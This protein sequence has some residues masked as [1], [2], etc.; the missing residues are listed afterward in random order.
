M[1]AVE[2]VTREVQNR[3]T[4]YPA[5]D[6]WTQVTGYID[7]E[8]RF[9]ELTDEEVDDPEKLA[10]WSEH[11]SG[12]TTGWPELLKHGRVVLLA[13]AGAGKTAEMRQ[14]AKRLVGEEK[15]AF[16]VALEE[17][18]RGPIDD[19]LSTDESNR[20]EEW[21]AAADALAWF[22]LDAVDE[23][24]LTQGKLDRA[25]RR[26]SRTLDSRLE[27]ARIII[28]CRP[29][30]WRP[31]LDAETVRNRLP[32]P[33]KSPRVS[34][35]PSEEMFVEAL[36]RAHR[37]T[38]PAA[39]ERR[40]DPHQSVL[41]TFMMLPM[42][43]KQ[44]ERFARQQGL[45]DVAAFLDAVRRHDAWTFARRPLD[46]VAL[47]ET[48]KQSGSLGTRAQRHDTNVTTKLK[49]DP[50]R[51][52][53]DVLSEARAGDGA[54]RLALAL[55]LTRTR[56]IRSPEQVLD[57]A[58]ADGVLDPDEI[59]PDWPTTER[60]SLLRRALFD[61]AT[62]GRV[63]FHHRSTQEYLAARRLR[64]LRKRGMSTKA[65]LRLLLATRYGVDVVYPSMRAIAAWLAL[66]DDA[67][68]NMLMER[69]PEALLSMGDPESLDVNTRARIVRRFVEAYGSGGARGL[70]I[71][72]A[73]VRRLA[74]PEL[75]PVIRECWNA[76]ANIDVRELLMEMIW[77]GAV[78][79][80][81]DL[82]HDV[83]FDRA[84]T[85]Y[86]RV[87]AIRALVACN[88]VDD[89]ADLASSMLARPA[90]WPDRV[91]YGVA[92]DLFPRFITAEQLLALIER[93]E[94][95]KQAAG[96][97]EWISQQIAEAVEPLSAA[98]V[99]LR[100]GLATLVQRGR[101]PRTELYNLCSR[102]DYLA[103]ALATL[104]AR[105]LA[106]LP[107]RPDAA[108]IRASVIA[109]RFVEG[110]GRD[111]RAGRRDLVGTLRTRMAAEPALRKD[112]FWSE[113]A[114]VDE[115]EKTDDGWRRLYYVKDG[116]VDSLSEDDRQWLLEDLADENR[117]D[118]HAVVLHALIGLWWQTGRRASELNEL[119]AH[120]K[121]DREL[122]RI[123]D[124]QTEPPKRDKSIEEQERKHEE[125]KRADAVRENRR[126]EGWKRWRN[127]LLADP[128]KAFSEGKRN[129]T[130]QNIYSF[131]NAL[132]GSQNR[133]D[134]WDKN[135][136]ADTFGSDVADRAED[137]F[138]GLW[139]STRACAWSARS[140]GTRN[141]VPGKWI[142]GLAGVSAEAAT[143]GWSTRLSSKDAGTA[144]AYAMIELNGLA[145]FITD[146]VESHPGEVARVIGTEARAELALS[147]DHEH[148][149]VVDDLAHANAELQRLCVPYLVD[150]LK[151]WPSVADSETD[152]RRPRHLD[153]LLHIL[154]AAD[155]QSV[156]EALAAECAIRY[157]DDPMAGLAVVWLK[158][159]F[160]FDPA[161]GA[162]ELIEDVEGRGSDAAIGK[163]VIEVFAALFDD[164][165]VDL[166]LPDPVQHAFLLAELVRLAHAFVR[167]EDDQVHDG[168]YT[169][170][171]RD[172][173]ERARSTLLQRLCNTPAPEARRALLDVVEE[174][175][176]AGQRDRLR[177]VARQRAAA[178]AEFK[179]FESK[180]VV[181]LGERYEVSPNDGSGLFA[182]VMD[183]LEDLSHDLAHHDLSDR[184][185]LL[186]IDDESEMQR[187]LSWRLD[188]RAK[189][190][191]RAIRE[192]EVADAKRPDIRLA[193]VGRVDHRVVIEVKIVDKWTF[194]ELAKA[195]HEQLAG[196]YLRHE[197]CTGGC[198][199]LTYHGRKQYW[200]R[201]K[202][203]NRLSF[204]DLVDV[205]DEKARALEREHQDRIRL[206][207]FGLDLTDSQSV[208]I[209][210]ERGVGCPQ[211]PGN[212]VA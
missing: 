169:P 61:P 15:F 19:I 194:A 180:A 168:V 202:G 89:T 204:R 150:A 161:R 121:G 162:Q 35:E 58:R 33:R 119:R 94:E 8:R 27:R 57:A 133:Y 212:E 135:A 59:L 42:S 130:I 36:R 96:G 11:V 49:E 7:V 116:V 90:S 68:R 137:A 20:F 69:E 156:R 65:L 64:S 136:L 32:V 77:Q 5:T 102:F 143:P 163:R 6:R 87:I 141:Q 28:S 165:P 191:Y 93:T 29:S 21:K 120:L 72:I 122:R 131:L 18:D 129:E 178:D 124:G 186:R 205:L 108:L 126:L 177:L 22:F 134:V 62:Y 164:D 193:T 198:L 48:W 1:S 206:K 50:D 25:L 2:R 155:D 66:W 175:E 197:K 185:L 14:Q 148:L 211:R 145:P 79:G 210:V 142:L 88:A 190:A 45:P 117:A 54:E 140:A 183:R 174:D 83:A 188:E 166:R 85:P 203:E 139:R 171:A 115:I 71:P 111:F 53:N 30:D 60:K 23:L 123:L 127:K 99:R 43:D 158:G 97:F 95:P 112:V 74:H 172:K 82:A 106:E 34:S 67:V 128:A 154:E 187:T 75:A 107:G 118:S 70:N 47:M 46:L 37:L 157:R 39:D 110:R 149:P 101:S 113:L 152:R 209:Q 103:P 153:Q 207:V 92:A 81:V 91:V 147:D 12:L 76:A 80:C 201:A 38:T 200:E 10:A 104:C 199:L 24:K 196:R 146:L 51:L 176:F 26:L 41:R 182:L 160:R 98:A 84:S 208:S 173:A 151:E 192:E 114:F 100:D 55:A 189:D 9:H 78:E 170:N 4:Q 105:Q 31:L 3:S 17:L 73:E 179:P 181:A 167:P 144:T 195:L 52:G 132:K 86:N 159:L 13:E 109:C 44:I 184:R 40:E 56:S 138:R 16:F 125:M 63:R